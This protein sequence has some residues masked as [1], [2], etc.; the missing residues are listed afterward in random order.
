MS[1]VIVFITID[2]LR[3][4]YANYLTKIIPK[5][6][7]SLIFSNF[8]ACGPYTW[9]SFPGI[10]TSTYPFTLN[11]LK[12]QSIYNRLSFVQILSKGG[13]VTI[14][15]SGGN[16]HLSASH[17]YNK[18]FRYFVDYIGKAQSSRRRVPNIHFV[19]SC[20]R[21]II[22]KLPRKSQIIIGTLYSLGNL[23]LG[24]K[25]YPDAS[26]VIK[27]TLN[28]LYEEI[29]KKRHDKFFIWAHIMD[30]HVPCSFI[31]N[32]IHNLKSF[33]DLFK[34]YLIT[35]G[36]YD[37]DIEF[38]RSIKEYYE[39]SLLYV[40]STL[41]SML[42]LLDSSYDNV[43]V[44]ITSDHGEEFGEHNAIGHAGL[45]H[46]GV[47]FTHLYEELLHVPLIITGKELAVKGLNTVFCSHL[48]IAPTI[49]SLADINRKS[50]YYKR[51]IK[52]LFIGKNLLSDSS[53]ESRYLVSE[54]E[55]ILVSSPFSLTYGLGNAY[56]LRK[57]GYKYI[58][59]PYLGEELYDL[60]S[61]PAETI[62]LIEEMPDV[63]KEFRVSLRNYLE[64]KRRFI[65]IYKVL[66]KLF[67]RC[68]A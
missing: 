65:A 11:S 9:A 24:Y 64:R 12:S 5:G 57:D 1:S 49:L 51:L 60:N 39:K 68:V 38:L 41:R 29:S 48:D 13:Y 53:S 21:K 8:Y 50:K 63:V 55:A 35:H 3:Y 32:Y 58:W 36:I 4:D 44:I 61:D 33:R 37:W 10:F 62:N 6:W 17:G 34:L 26:Y 40:I 22:R 52:R 14:G 43:Y 27:D 16:P 45:A 66:F 23:W 2:C 18:G 20:F 7:E 46:L 59:H 54:S 15:N 19:K 56:A 31:L 28:I 25:P 67:K 42:D 30:L 47:H